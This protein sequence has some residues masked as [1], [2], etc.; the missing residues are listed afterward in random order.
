MS[1]LLAL[2]GVQGASSSSIPEIGL[3]EDCHHHENHCTL[4]LVCAVDIDTP[5]PSGAVSL[6][7]PPAYCGMT[8]GTTYTTS[9]GD[10][11]LR[12]YEIPETTECVT[13]TYNTAFDFVYG[14][15]VE[16][17]DGIFDKGV[18]GYLLEGDF[19]VSVGYSMPWYGDGYFIKFDA[20][21]NLRAGG[22]VHIQF[23]MWMF[24]V[25]FWIAMI[26][27]DL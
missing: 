18:V 22:D 10:N 11:P 23:D 9:G 13:S 21:P 16:I 7:I 12:E 3:D 17:E 19:D 27:A 4:N 26:L 15:S 5:S 8:G 24:K 1:A 20:A 2:K 25:H 6:C 14:H